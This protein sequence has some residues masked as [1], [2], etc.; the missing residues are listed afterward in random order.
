MP[1]PVLAIFLILLLTLTLRARAESEEYQ[2]SVLI[3]FAV[4]DLDRSIEFYRDVVG[5]E[6]EFRIDELKWARFKTE[7]PHPGWISSLAA[8]T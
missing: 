3:Q 7:V 5:L 8:A 2:P 4:S 1:R 6:F